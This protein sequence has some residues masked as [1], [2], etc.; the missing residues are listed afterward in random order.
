MSSRW[1]ALPLTALGLALRAGAATEPAA[2]VLLSPPA[3]MEIT[4]LATYF[5]WLPVAGVS[6]FEVQVARDA[7]FADLLRTRHTTNRLYHH[8]LWFPRDPLPAGAYHWRVRGVGAA[9]TSAWSEV[10]ALT[11]NT[12]RAAAP[13]PVRPLGPAQPLFLMRNRAWDPRRHRDHVDEII[14]PALAGS[15]VVDDIRLAGEQVFERAAA[16]EAMGVTFVVWNNRAQVSLATLEYLFQRHPHCIGTAEGEHFWG[17]GWERGPEGH[18]SEQD[19]VRRAWALCAKYGRFYFQG[20]GEHAVHQWTVVSHECRDD[21]RRNGRYFVPMFKS[22]VG[23]VALHSMGAVEGLLA[24]GWVENCG[25]W[26]DEFVWG[27]SGFGKLGELDCDPHDSLRKHGT[28][29]CPWT[30]DLQMWLMGMV[31]GG[32]AFQ[33]E[34]AHQ[35][36]AE[37]RPAEYYRRFFLPFIRAVVERGLLPSR[38]AWRESLRVAVA[39]DYDRARQRHGGQLAGDFAFLNHLYALRRKPFQELIP[40]ES[41]YGIVA[42]LPPG[43]D[44]IDGLAEVVPL[45]ELADPA[46]AAERFDRAYPRR[47]AGDP[48][49]WTC[50]GTIIVTCSREN[51]PARQRFVLPLEAGPARELAGMIGTH[52]YLLGK[53]SATALWFQVNGEHPAGTLEVEVAGPRAPTV[54]IVPVGAGTAEWESAR[55]RLR[56][57]LA[58]RDGPVEVTVE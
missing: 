29:Q 31:A 16:Y 51:E 58:L 43:V 25:L 27:E 55:G 1:F 54:R 18:L 12:N 52:Q 39:C 33:L 8:N 46:R 20:E 6:N 30:Y 4:D 9:G 7:D 24:A 11:V 48:F 14:P 44:R 17:W 21:L 3:G 5:Q 38:P 26:A 47:F 23:H 40:D 56:V 15:I 36:T 22:T 45:A 50:D 34:S 10:R 2:P 53:S 49:V 41:R 57:R 19:Y 37:G 32:T 13:A 42:L 28:K 35:W